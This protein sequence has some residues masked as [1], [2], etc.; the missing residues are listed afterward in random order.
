MEEKTLSYKILIFFF[1]FVVAFVWLFICCVS[2][3]N[4]KL[5]IL[6]NILKYKK[7][8]VFRENAQTYSHKYASNLWQK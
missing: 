3:K 5:F 2:T 1:E 7:Y 8:R 6:H 4:K